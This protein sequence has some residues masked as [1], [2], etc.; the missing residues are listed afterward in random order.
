ML[1]LRTSSQTLFK[2]QHV[3]LEFMKDH[4]KETIKL[5]SALKALSGFKVIPKLC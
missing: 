5:V 2:M 4:L 3:R 1:K